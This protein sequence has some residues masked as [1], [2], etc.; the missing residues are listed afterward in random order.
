MTQVQ[1]MTEAT[2]EELRLGILA[3]TMN[4]SVTWVVAIPFVIFFPDLMKTKIGG[5]PY[6]GVG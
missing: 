2:R 5:T 6:P 3:E 4:D 1:T